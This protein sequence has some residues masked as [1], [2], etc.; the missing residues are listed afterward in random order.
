MYPLKVQCCNSIEYITSVTLWNRLYCYIEEMGQ[1]DWNEV[2]A[3]DS[4]SLQDD[5]EKAERMFNILA[6]VVIYISW[7]LFCCSPII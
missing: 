3:V 4:T 1:L 6:E 5:E 2:L 7:S